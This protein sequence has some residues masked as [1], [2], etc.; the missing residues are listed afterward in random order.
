M[1]R[2]IVALILLMAFTATAQRGQERSHKEKMTLEQRAN[3]HTKKMTLALDLTQSQQ[4][5]VQS[6]NLKNG[7]MRE[8]KME[9]RKA[10]KESD[11]T[12]KPSSEE[13]YAMQMERLDHQIAQKAEMKK[14][15]SKEQME[16]WEKIV[17][18][19][20]RKHQKRRKEHRKGSK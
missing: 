8:A 13:R 9:E 14:I 7:K 4:E 11:D 5:Q 6:L 15:L 18:H 12:K 19:K 16:K 10:R 1:K 17:V 3:L 2:L 20:K